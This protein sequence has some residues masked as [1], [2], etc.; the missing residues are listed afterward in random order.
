M[1][2]WK[3]ENTEIYPIVML[4]EGKFILEYQMFP[5]WEESSI[6]CPTEQKARELAKELNEVLKR[7]KGEW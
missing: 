7:K 3:P 5:W 2:T 6:Y 4:F 1:T